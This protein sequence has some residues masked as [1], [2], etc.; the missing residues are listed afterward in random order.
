MKT[1]LACLFAVSMLVA[2]PAAGAEEVRSVNTIS[3]VGVGYAPIPPTASRAEAE[4]DYGSA[5]INAVVN[6][7]TKAEAL[8]KATEAKV[9]PIEA[10]SENGRR[11]AVQCKNALGESAPYKGAEP[12]SG[13]AGAPTIA[14]EPALPVRVVAP[15]AAKKVTKPSPRKKKKHR[16]IEHKTRRVIAKKAE[17]GENIATSCELS[18]EVLLIYGLEAAH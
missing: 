17:T 18:S 3:V 6:G 11:A 2:A 7:F 1:C 12:D 8:A 4:V 13:T 9:G 14:V 16:R 5:L 15:V 10:V